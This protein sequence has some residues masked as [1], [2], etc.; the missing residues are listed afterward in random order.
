MK[1][2]MN[3]L[4]S[5][6]KDVE[7]ELA[8]KKIRILALA[9]TAVIFIFV[10]LHSKLYLDPELDVA[11]GGILLAISLICA[12][13]CGL[14][15]A[16]RLKVPEKL[17]RI[18]T[19]I[20]FFLMPVITLQM[21]EAFDG[22]F[23]YDFSIPTFCL[24]YLIILCFYLVVYLCSGRM[25]LAGLVVNITLY[26]WSMLNYFIELFRGTPF[27]PMDIFT[28]KTGLSVASG[29]VYELSWQLVLASILML[30]VYLIN[31][32]IHNF[33][34]AK[35]RFK[36]LNRVLP[37]GFVCIFVMVFFFSDSL[38]NAGYKPDFWNQS[39]GY[40]KT[41]TFF[42][43]CLNTKYLHVSK[44][45]EYNANG[46]ADILESFLEE[47]GTSTTSETSTNILTG[48]NNYTASTDG[49]QPNIICIMNESFSD[50]GHLGN[51][52]TNEDYMPFIHSLTEN[53][54]KGNLYMPVFGAGTSNSEFEFLT[55]NSMSSMPIGSNVYQ[56]Y[57]HSDQ[58]S[59][60]STL[61]SLGYST[62]AFHPYYKDGWN[63][64]EVYTDFGFEKYT[65]IEDFI[66][67]DI[68]ETYKQNND[69]EEYAD[70][71]E[72]KYP[73]Q[74]MLL[75]RFIS[76]DYDFKMLEQM[77]ENRD[78]TKPFSIL[79]VTMQNHGGY[80]MSYSNFM[81][82]IY[83]TNL[84]GDY[85][86]A[87]RY[88]SLVKESDTA[89]QNLVQYFSQVKEP[90]II[91]MFGD[92]L[93]SI[94]TDFYEELMGKSL[95]K[96]SEEEQ[97]SRYETPFIIWAN[98]D[99]PEATVDKMSANYLSTLL[100]QVAGMPMTS[101]NKFLAAMYQQLPVINTVGYIDRNNNYYSHGQ[102]SDY[103]NL[104]NVYSRIEYNNLLDTDNRDDSLFYLNTGSATDNDSSTGDSG[105]DTSGNTNAGNTA[106]NV[107]S[108][109]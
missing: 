65:A 8:G 72:A 86:Q 74:N 48:E 105:T 92:H 78:T 73:G 99:I 11:Y 47:N 28:A 103:T 46:T 84:Q 62:Q 16:V 37:A 39:R 67:N 82:K 75:R 56:S 77:Y 107:D 57:I 3:R 83:I 54:I 60:V 88:L 91:C 58:A 44:P 81:Q 51:L 95:D 27:V 64:P 33:K 49:T 2:F 25:H 76:D 12:P 108:S 42:N 106:D 109:N 29:Y 14:L 40:H 94:E 87:N 22:K 7:F 43:F 41:G 9:V 101:Y 69:A 36:V 50:L 93:P 26:V 79:N 89:F 24:N 80:A 6:F 45:S 100:Q 18:L 55:G 23:I 38:A 35:L 32:H 71:L 5:L 96:L 66:D 97:Q 34:P 17:S 59:L 68:L 13:I 63:R 104:L 102:A 10:A 31:K 1:K 19:T 53:T 21:V 70:L 85:P 90:T 15:I 98:Y 30:M 61:K 52:Q 4:S 20:V